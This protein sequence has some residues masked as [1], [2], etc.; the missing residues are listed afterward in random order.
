MKHYNNNS[1][2]SIVISL[3]MVGFLIVVTSWVF[4]LVLW[5][6]NDN[7]WREN[8]LKAFAA[9]EWAQEL[10]LLQIKEK[11]YGYYWTE[12]VKD[13]D[14]ILAEDPT[15]LRPAKDPKISY[16][17]NSKTNSYGESLSPLWYAIVPLFILDDAEPSAPSFTDP[18]N[19]SSAL[20]LLL[21][22]P[23]TTLIWNLLWEDGWMSWVWGFSQITTSTLSTSS[24]VT[25][26]YSIENFINTRGNKLNYLILFNSDPDNSVNYTLTSNREFTKPETTIISSASVWKYKQNL[27]TTLDNTEFLNILRYSIYSN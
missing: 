18:D 14:P 15:N 26:D 23:W 24:S 20:S 22:A 13:D 21:E 25:P 8:Y 5:E 17:L 1:G 6:L 12:A 11:G 19:P 10:A 27:S 3:L 16:N 4:N 9:A 2:Y 7:R